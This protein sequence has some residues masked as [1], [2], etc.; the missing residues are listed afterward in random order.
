MEESKVFNLAVLADLLEVLGLGKKPLFERWAERIQDVVQQAVGS[1]ERSGRRAADELTP[2]TRRAGARLRE[3]RERAR[4]RTRGR[5]DAVA[6]SRM[7]TTI[8]GL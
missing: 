3:V 8:A 7:L 5:R 6:M 4:T 1:L 2:A